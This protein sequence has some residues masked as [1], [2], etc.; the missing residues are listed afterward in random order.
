MKKA[1]I[2][3]LI[4]FSASAPCFAEPQEN[5]ASGEQEKELVTPRGTVYVGMPIYKLYDVFQEEQDRVLIPQVILNKECHV[6][7]DISSGNPNDVI[8]FYIKDGKVAS[9]TKGYV[10]A[11]QNK[12]SQYEYDNDSHIE[13]WFFPK[14][15]ARWDGTKV[16]LLDWNKL[17]QAQKVMFI[18]EYVDQVN[19][20]FKTGINVNI[21]K[22]IL[23][24]NYYSDN[25]P[26]S[27]RNIPAGDAVNNLLISD[28][29]AKEAP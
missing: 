27:C 7:R 2:I 23:G 21:D 18:T 20:Q 8:T 13:T 10:A 6:F 15:K 19:A 1:L 3:A 5:T 16:N 11:C 14:E 24:M 28:G 26:M 29:K 4:L 25:C 22:Y 9:W 12:G 17:T